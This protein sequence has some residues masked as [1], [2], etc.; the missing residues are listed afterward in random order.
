MLVINEFS[1]AKVLHFFPPHCFVE[2]HFR[3]SIMSEQK[4]ANVVEDI[5]AGLVPCE[6]SKL[7]F[8][9]LDL[10]KSEFRPEEFNTVKLPFEAERKDHVLMSPQF[11]SS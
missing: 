9:I 3:T 10:L 7:R 5:P 4:E 6:V 1:V 2:S 11:D 8:K